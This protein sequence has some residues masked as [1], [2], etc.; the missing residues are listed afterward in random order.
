MAK[1][2]V[3]HVTDDLD[4]S[5]DAAEVSFSYNGIE[6]RIDLSKKN[7]SALEKALKPYIDG[8]TKMSKRHSGQRLSTSNSA[9]RD[10]AAIR[11]WAAA[12]GIQ[13]SDRGR[14][15]RDVIERY[16]AAH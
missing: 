9:K 6:Y 16:D 13:V 14:I 10:L 4:G 3:I 7:R 15:S 12:Q 11:S 2:T 8:G 1:T 5:K